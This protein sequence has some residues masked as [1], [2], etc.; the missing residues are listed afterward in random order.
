MSNKNI[1]RIVNIFEGDNHEEPSGKRS[2]SISSSH[3]V[4]KKKSGSTSKRYKALLTC[5]ICDGD[6]HG[7]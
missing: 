3:E 5:V 7:N 6:A 1:E 4:K 2:V